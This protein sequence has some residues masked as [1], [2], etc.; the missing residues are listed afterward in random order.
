MHRLTAVLVM[1]A[2]VLLGAA[3]AASAQGSQWAPSFGFLVGAFNSSDLTTLRDVVENISGYDAVLTGRSWDLCGA[4]GRASG[5][6]TRVCYTQ[7]RIDDG[8]GLFDEF[9]DGVAQ[10]VRVK[11]FKAE[12][13]WRIG[14]RSWPV[15]PTV[16]LHGGLGKVSGKVV[17]THYDF[18]FN[19]QTQQFS[20]G[21]PIST[22]T[23][24][25]AE[26]LAFI[27]DEWTLIGGGSIGATATLANHLTMTVGVYGMEFPGVYKGQVQFVYWPR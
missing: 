1:T 13:V 5:S 16:S 19:Q 8:S 14:R 25:A 11:G 10:N 7:L 3:S 22:E 12:H 24:P 26:Y 20:K 17:F 18:A 23:Q 15:A 6:Y 21:A 4:R 9:S 2:A 27:K